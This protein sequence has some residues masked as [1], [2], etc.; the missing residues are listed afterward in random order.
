MIDLMIRLV[1]AHAIGD[2]ALQ[3]QYIGDCKMKDSL[4]GLTALA[5]HAL[6]VGGVTWLLVPLFDVWLLTSG[7]H[8]MIDYFSSRSKMRFEVRHT[9]DQL[10][11][12]IVMI[13]I[14]CLYK[15][16]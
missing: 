11:H 8:F 5:G 2:L 1:T 13:L 9:L 6:I 7:S 10:A 14:W 4:K 16:V 15:G 3:T 12:L